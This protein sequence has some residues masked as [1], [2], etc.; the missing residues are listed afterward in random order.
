MRILSSGSCMAP[1]RELMSRM[2]HATMRTALI[3]QHASRERDQEIADKVS[4]NVTKAR[5]AKGKGAREG[6][7]G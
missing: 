4:R 5:R 2:G 3:Y 6:H 1:C 7:D